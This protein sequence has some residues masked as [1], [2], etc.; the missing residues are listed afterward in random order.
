VIV[1]SQKPI[2][3]IIEL[4][5]D[6]KKLIV[7]GCGAC[8][9]VCFAGGERETQALALGLRLAARREKR[10]VEITVE[11][12]VRQCEWE[13]IEPLSEKIAAADAVVSTACGVGVQFLAER[14]P[15]K[16]ILPGLNTS[17]MGGPIE[18]GVWLENCGGCG[19][20]VLADTG[21]VCPVARCAKSML[22]GPC[23]GSQN[24]KC[25]VSKDIDCAWQLI[26]DR[27]KL[28]GRLDQ[29][30]PLAPPKDWT[31]ARDGGQRKVVR[32]DL[33]LAAPESE[34]ESRKSEG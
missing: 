18:Q 15:D 21:G 11:M 20:C 10:P 17:F 13:F 19:N 12:N 2:A 1:A 25:E 4:T 34:V 28:Q 22:N 8:V 3:E 29:L 23:G 6:H 14:W 31:P 30:T 5:R 16:R 26:Y 24:G 27:L 7:I 9:T 32:E 33:R